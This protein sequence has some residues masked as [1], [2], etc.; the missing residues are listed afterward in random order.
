ME[1]FNWIQYKNQ[2]VII[3]RSKITNHCDD[4]L[5]EM[6]RNAELLNNDQYYFW[7]YRDND[8]LLRLERIAKLIEKIQECGYEEWDNSMIGSHKME[9]AGYLK[10]NEMMKQLYEHL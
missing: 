10:D 6:K 2:K 1:S 7:S 8:R 3:D 4:W 5:I 9:V